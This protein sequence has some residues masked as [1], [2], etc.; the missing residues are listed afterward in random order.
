M[1]S[2]PKGGL[3]AVFLLPIQRNCKL[4]ADVEAAREC[5]RYLEMGSISFSGSYR[6]EYAFSKLQIRI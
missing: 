6:D 1:A 3:S 2:D 5:R 4:S